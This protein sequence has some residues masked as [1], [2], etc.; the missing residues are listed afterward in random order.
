MSD[1]KEQFDAAVDYVQSSES[2]SAK[3]SK[4]FLL[5]MYAL[6]KQSSEGDVKGKRPGITHFVAR[7]KYDAWAKR[8]GT[9]TE[10]AMQ[11]YIAEVEKIKK[12]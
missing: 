5:T 7:S 4:D 11:A 12:R 8:K 1:L 2:G 3:P 9:S 10:Q 6:F